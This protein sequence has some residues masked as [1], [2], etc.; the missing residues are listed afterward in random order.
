MLCDLRETITHLNLRG[1]LVGLHLPLPLVR[2]SLERA[3][4][5]EFQHL[6][7]DAEGR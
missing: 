5:A 2:Q 3:V 7:A 6:A 1:D 4:R